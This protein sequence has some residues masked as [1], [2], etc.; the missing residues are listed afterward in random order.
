M[1]DTSSTHTVDVDV[2]SAEAKI[3]RLQRK[4]DRLQ[5]TLE[6]VAGAGGAVGGGGGGGTS[7]ERA[8]KKAADKA[9]KEQERADKAAA[10][11]LQQE[12]DAD[13]RAER[14]EKERKR[15]LWGGI[16]RTAGVTAALTGAGTIGA[17]AGGMAGAP[18]AVIGGLGGAAAAAV[19][20]LGSML[21]KTGEIIGGAIGA[22][23]DIGGTILGVGGKIAGAAVTGLSFAASSRYGVANRIAD[24]Q[25]AGVYAPL[26]G[27]GVRMN[28]GAALGLLPEEAAGVASSA[29][30]AAGYRGSMRGVGLFSGMAYG[31]SPGAIGALA[32]SAA[33]SSGD[34]ARGFNS[35]VRNAAIRDGLVGSKLDAALMRIASAIQQLAGGG[36]MSNLGSIGSMTYGVQQS[37]GALAPAGAAH[38][39]I[40]SLM[41]LP[42]QAKQSL[43]APFGQAAQGLVLARA[44]RQSRGGGLDGLLAALED[45]GPSGALDALRGSPSIGRRYLAQMLPMGTGAADAALSAEPGSGGPGFGGVGVG[46]AARTRA[47]VSARVMGT[48]SDQ[49]AAQMIKA[50]GDLQVALQEI[51]AGADDF[52]AKMLRGIK[53]VIEYFKPRP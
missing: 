9:K 18:G 46:A 42:G 34:S 4:A 11:K 28:S 8:A 14:T 40:G 19:S 37:I 29:S 26:S 38:N 50:M 32:G 30:L 35:N 53:E 44:A 2:T 15:A 33:Y 24:Y 20:G 17:Y 13:E 49:S 16:R 12:M 31:A 48:M 6:R 47:E 27:G 7:E 43:L 39:V 45:M 1:A 3:D 5:A 51:S 21:S 41:G 10:R 52:I 22:L 23:A 25:R 36:I